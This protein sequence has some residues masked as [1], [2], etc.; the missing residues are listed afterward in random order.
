MDT[1][2]LYQTLERAAAGGATLG[3]LESQIR[4]A[5]LLSE[6]ERE[7]AWLYAWALRKRH[8][9]PLPRAGPASGRLG[10]TG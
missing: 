1:Q 10:P 3:E 4:G 6:V 5:G 9:R 8:E 7:E 2:S